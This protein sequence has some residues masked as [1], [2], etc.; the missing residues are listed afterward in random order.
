MCLCRNTVLRNCGGVVSESTVGGDA[1][2]QVFAPIK[3]AAVSPKD[4]CFRCSVQC[5]C[6]LSVCSRHFTWT[7]TDCFF[8]NFKHTKI[9]H[10]ETQKSWHG[11][12]SHPS[13][14]SVFLLLGV[15]LPRC[16][17]QA[18]RGSPDIS[19]QTSTTFCKWG[20]EEPICFR[21]RMW[22]NEGQL[23]TTRRLIVVVCVVKLSVPSKLLPLSTQILLVEVLNPNCYR[24]KV[25]SS[26]T[27]THSVKHFKVFGLTKKLLVGP[28]WVG[29]TV[30]PKNKKVTLS[31]AKSCCVVCEGFIKT[32]K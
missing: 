18:H 1:S 13:Q 12:I 5:Y 20:F 11:Q 24:L 28:L 16:S 31:A 29:L 8:F 2:P 9:L 6:K 25:S 32:S 23:S 7:T 17:S 4:I 26:Q 27:A 14:S 19:L 30:T 22:T 21:S 3:P 10:R 15:N